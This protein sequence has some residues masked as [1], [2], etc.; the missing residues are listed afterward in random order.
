M[1][2]D[3]IEE[4]KDRESED[5]LRS[6]GASNKP[7]AEASKRAG[8]D[9]TKRDD[10]NDYL[11]KLRVRPLPPLQQAAFILL[12]WIGVCIMVTLLIVLA[13]SIFTSP[14][15]PSEIPM[16]ADGNVD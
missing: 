9:D 13:Y 6:L 1:T 12:K 16:T 14:H 11:R 2:V 8:K 3:N 7:E 10:I 15:L 4:G 5:I